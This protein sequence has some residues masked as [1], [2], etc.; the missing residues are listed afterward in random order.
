M[1]KL[2]Y[3]KVCRETSLLSF[4]ADNTHADVRNLNHTDVVS[5]VANATYP[6]SRGL[7]DENGNF[8]F[9]SWRATTGNDGR[10]VNGNL[11]EFLFI[12]SEE[13]LKLARL[14]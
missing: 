6:L 11:D 5:S 9:L 1:R 8:G 7:L 4:F 2:E 10:Q 3:G 12:M 14:T 13:S